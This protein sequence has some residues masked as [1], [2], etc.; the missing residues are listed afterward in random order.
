MSDHECR[1][2]LE[3][4]HY[5]IKQNSREA[6]Q[7]AWK[8]LEYWNRGAPAPWPLARHLALVEHFTLKG[9][10]DHMMRTY[11]NGQIESKLWLVST[12]IDVLP[13]RPYRIAIV[14]GWTGL[15]SNIIFWRMPHLVIHIRQIELD[16]EA[17]WIAKPFLADARAQKK[18]FQT[19][20]DAN[21]FD[22]GKYYH[23]VI[24]C[25]T[26]HF[27]ENKWYENVAKS[28]LVAIQ[29]TDN[30][31]EPTHINCVRDLTEFR[32]KYPVEMTLFRGEL[33]LETYSR[34]MRIGRR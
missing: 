16:P 31:L 13:Q 3:L 26:E 2:F 4:C 10:S 23:L 27:A 9:H 6:F 28:R 1:V 15:L 33:K 25:S 17:Q 29:S 14:G 20:Q 19:T 7:T 12:L 5:L 22:F 32:V 30:T 11:S 18:F 21:D 34:F 24:N 8:T